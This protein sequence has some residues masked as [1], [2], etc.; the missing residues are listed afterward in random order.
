MAKESK[1]VAEFL[2]FIS[3]HVSKGGSYPDRAICEYY[4][5]LSARKLNSL[6]S[7]PYWNRYPMYT[8]WPRDSGR[9]AY[10]RYLGGSTIELCEYVPRLRETFVKK[11][12]G[13]LLCF[14]MDYLSGKDRLRASRRAI[15]SKD[16][17]AKLRAAHILPTSFLKKHIAETKGPAKHVMVTR[18]G[19]DNCCELLVNDGNSYYRSK[20]I[21]ASTLPIRESIMSNVESLVKAKDSVDSWRYG[22]DM[23]I[24][25]SKLEDEDL[26]YFLDTCRSVPILDKYIRK[27]L[28]YSSINS[29]GGT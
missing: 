17:R 28:S 18:L 7:D 5:G 16:G 20:A 6:I 12:G 14:S 29:K 4:A 23:K 21:G 1:A 13:I 22:N 8:C 24:L 10:G 26:L 9:R 3:S 2:D 25:L 27:R 15:K 19:L 11:A